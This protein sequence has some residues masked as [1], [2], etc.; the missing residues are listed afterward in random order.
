MFLRLVLWAAVA[1][2]SLLTSGK[3]AEL[4]E[5]G[6]GEPRV[7]LEA[8]NAKTLQCDR[9]CDNVCA[10]RGMQVREVARPRLSKWLV[11]LKEARLDIG[12]GEVHHS[13]ISSMPG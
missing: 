8:A 4:N 3:G 1:N 7:S 2:G 13:Q 12:V 10:F 9:D 5:T 11:D 6:L